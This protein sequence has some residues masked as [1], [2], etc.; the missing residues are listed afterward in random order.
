MLLIVSTRRD[1]EQVV[2]NHRNFFVYKQMHRNMIA[3]NTWTGPTR[4]SKL[5]S[6]SGPRGGVAA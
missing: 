1:T 2:A 6:L 5:L 4:L 3:D